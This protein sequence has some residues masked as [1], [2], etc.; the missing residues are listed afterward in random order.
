M[1]M[2]SLDQKCLALGNNRSRCVVVLRSF[3]DNVTSCRQSLRGKCDTVG[4]MVL[5]IGVTRCCVTLWH[6]RK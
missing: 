1:K 2:S 3:K 5:L 6:Q 4:Y